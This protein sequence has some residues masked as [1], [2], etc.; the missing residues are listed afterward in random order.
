MVAELVARVALQQI[1]KNTAARVARIELAGNANKATRAFREFERVHDATPKFV[2]E[3]VIHETLKEAKK[4]NVKAGTRSAKAEKIA[5][6]ERRA[7]E[8]EATAKA[9]RENPRAKQDP[10]KVKDLQRSL[11][12]SLDAKTKRVKESEV[13]RTPATDAYDEWKAN[14]DPNASARKQAAE[15]RK[16]LK[17]SD[18]QGID[19]KGARLQQDRGRAAFGKEYDTWSPEQRGAA[20]EGFRAYADTANT[21]KKSDQVLAEF[22]AAS[23]NEKM[24][25]RFAMRQE[26]DGAGGTRERMVAV[27]RP[28]ADEAEAEAVRQEYQ[29]RKLQ[30][31]M[32]RTKPARLF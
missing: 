9:L 6:Q 12:R 23:A 5:N 17:I 13:G 2:R 1:M 32:D 11:Q 20:W 21:S 18:Y 26:S 7:D 4:L 25:V 3:M 24:E 30:E 15:T 16:L 22:Q 8:R 27:V 10:E 28:H 29:A 19:T 14:R 31:L